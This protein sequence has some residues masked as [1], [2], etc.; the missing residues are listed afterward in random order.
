MPKPKKNKK[1]RKFVACG[2][3]G[4]TFYSYSYSLDR[5]VGRM[6]PELGPKD[7]RVKGS[8]FAPGERFADWCPVNVV[9]QSGSM[10]GLLTVE[11]IL[12]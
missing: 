7:T 1:G 9:S 6:H 5:H 4:C 3:P 11:T 8:G 10:N 2:M 12:H